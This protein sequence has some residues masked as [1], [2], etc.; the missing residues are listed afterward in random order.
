MRRI[1]A[2]LI[3]FFVFVLCFSFIPHAHAQQTGNIP[4]DLILDLQTAELNPAPDQQ[5]ILHS[6]NTQVVLTTETG[7]ETTIVPQTTINPQAATES[8]TDALMPQLTT[9]EQVVTE[10]VQVPADQNV[11]VTPSQNAEGTNTLIPGTDISIPDDNAAPSDNSTNPN[12][13]APTESEEN[14]TVSVSPEDQQGQDTNQQGQNQQNQNAPSTQP[15]SQ[16]SPGVVITGQPVDSTQ[17][18]PSGSQPQTNTSSNQSVSP[19]SNAAPTDAG[20]QQTSAPSSQPA[21]NSPTSDT[22]SPAPDTSTPAVQ[23][24]AIGPTIGSFFRQ[25]FSTVNHFLTG[26]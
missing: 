7:Q 20:G 21:D 3:S 11:S 24:S 18:V 6:E 5:Q 9:S 25:L 4:S 14:P 16:P 19:A 23:G 15:S 17:T 1:T 2:F 10:P 26:K 13:P 22:S 12:L 8:T